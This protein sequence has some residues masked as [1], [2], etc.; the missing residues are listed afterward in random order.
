MP[1]EIEFDK[2]NACFG[3]NPLNKF[4]FIDVWLK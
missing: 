4:K 1:Y 3:F 2:E